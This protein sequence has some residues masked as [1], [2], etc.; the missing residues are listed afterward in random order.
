MFMHFIIKGLFAFL[1]SVSRSARVM[2]TRLSSFRF[3]LARRAIHVRLHRIYGPE[4]RH[5]RTMA[6]VL[7]DLECIG[8]CGVYV[9]LESQIENGERACRMRYVKC[10]NGMEAVEKFS[11]LLREHRRSIGQTGPLD[12]RTSRDDRTNDSFVRFL[13]RVEENNTL[14]MAEFIL[15]TL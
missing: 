9:F 2:K 3:N 12:F 15:E 5:P 10:A 7:A 8:R 1:R 13:V 11:D 14:T 6:Q 4:T